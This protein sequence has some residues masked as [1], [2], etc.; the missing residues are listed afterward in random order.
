MA[1]LV[2]KSVKS[3]RGYL[4]CISMTLHSASWFIIFLTFPDSSPTVDNGTWD[5]AYM[6]PTKALILV[7]AFFIG[8]GEAVYQV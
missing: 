2:S 4:S 1:A 7:A 8:V 5:V 6:K 3:P